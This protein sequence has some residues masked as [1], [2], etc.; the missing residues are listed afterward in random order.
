MK[1]VVKM[2]GKSYEVEV[3][4]AN[5]FHMLT[6]E[7]A[8]TGKVAPAAPVAAPVVPQAAPVAAPAPAPAPAAPAPVASGAAQVESPMV[9]SI[10]D[11]K[12]AVGDVVKAG[13]TVFIM[14]AMKMENEIVAPVDGTIAEI[15][16]AKGASVTTGQV[17]AVLK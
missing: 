1:Y 11:V 15:C 5:P 12:K 9:G 10:L 7:E 3:E 2:D 8:V 13:D 16:V 4:R 17:L 14:E 6:R